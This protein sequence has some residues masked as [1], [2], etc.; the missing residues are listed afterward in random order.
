MSIKITQNKCVG[1]GSCAEVCPG[2]LIAIKSSTAVIND[3]KRCWGCASCI[4]ECPHGAIA[5]Y[6]GSDIGGMG[7]M[8]TVKQQNPLLHWT[9]TMPNGTTKTIITNRTESN[10]Y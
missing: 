3:P 10:K 2:S 6:L 9:I 4:K 5:L 7:G 8:L 1:C